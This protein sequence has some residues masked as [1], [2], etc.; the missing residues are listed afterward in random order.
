MAD[1]DV[2]S[3]S[4]A[5]RKRALGRRVRELRE[6]C[7]YT[8]EELAEAAQ[9]HRTYVGSVERGERNVSLLNLHALADA[10]GVPVSELVSDPEQ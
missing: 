3:Q 4:S 9:M 7:G 5:E 1:K 2:P 6:A 10:L 8:Q